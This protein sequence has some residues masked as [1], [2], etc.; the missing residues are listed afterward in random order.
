MNQ[1][2][3]SAENEEIWQNMPEFRW[4][5]PVKGVKAGAEILAY[6]RPKNK[7]GEADMTAVTQSIAA[8]I[9]EDPE[10]ALRRL[11]EMRG[12][13]G[14]NSLIVASTRGKGKV[15]MI[16]TDSMW[17][18]RSKA[19]DHLHHRFWG[20]VM[21][22]GAGEKLRAGN[23]H[24]RIGTD[25]LRYG[26]GEPVKAFVRMLDKDFNGMEGMEPR[27]VL[28][29]PDGDS[30]ASA[31]YPMPRPDANGFYE[32][33]ITGCD[34]PGVYTLNLECQKAV[35]VL[36]DKYP[37]GLE[38]S[39][40]VVTAKRPAEDVDITATRETAE[41]IAK[42]TGGRVLSPSEY[43]T[44]DD[45]FG[46]GSKSLQDRVEYQLWSLPPIFLLIVA[47]LTAEWILRK[48][49]SLT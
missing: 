7:G 36:G 4:R 35:K 19:G 49:V 43:V 20:Q 47:L 3:S 31:F 2:S 22:W 17:R 1:S 33:E 11:E 15:L 46:G 29:R 48:R 32:C 42:A 39:F 34:T 40:V 13:Q 10:V 24:V 5:I 41:R 8:T 38:T 9:E 30:R 23:D 45:D 6:A 25:Q 26:A 27:L 18:L 14:R 28:R 37:Q 12:E 21:R 16:N 44:L